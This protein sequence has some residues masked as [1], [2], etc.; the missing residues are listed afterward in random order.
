M[1]S[2]RFLSVT[3]YSWQ[4]SSES[5]WSEMSKLRFF[6]SRH[7]LRLLRKKLYIFDMEH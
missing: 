6:F 2:D 3:S 1:I 7:M 5:V 4:I